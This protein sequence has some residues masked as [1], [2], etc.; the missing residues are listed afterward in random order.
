M[1][2]SWTFSSDANS[3]FGVIGDSRYAFETSARGSIVNSRQR[4]SIRACCVAFVYPRPVDGKCSSTV[5]R[6]TVGS[7]DKDRG[8]LIV[9]SRDSEVAFSL[10]PNI[11]LLSPPFLDSEFFLFDFSGFSAKADLCRFSSGSLD[12]LDETLVV[13]SDLVDKT[14]FVSEALRFLFICEDDAV[15]PVTG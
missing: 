2:A 4:E 1:V 12:L 9:D 3:I 7:R 15:I 13:V 8:C 11:L 10:L 6:T 14:P 5:S